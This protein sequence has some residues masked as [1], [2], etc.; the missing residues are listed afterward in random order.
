MLVTDARYKI[1]KAFTFD[2][3]DELEAFLD[4]ECA[5]RIP[6]ATSGGYRLPATR[7]VLDVACV[8]FIV[9]GTTVRLYDYLTIADVSPYQ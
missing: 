3:I 9:D 7:K 2:T 8:A 1:T 5:D 6:E 4:S